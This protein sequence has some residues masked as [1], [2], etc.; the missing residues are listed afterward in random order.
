[1]TAFDVL[2]NQHTERNTKSTELNKPE[3]ESQSGGSWSL[4]KEFSDE[5]RRSLRS[6]S[7]TLEQR[8]ESPDQLPTVEDLPKFAQLYDKINYDH[9][10]GLTKEEVERA[11]SD[12][13]LKSHERQMAEI[14]QNNYDTIRPMGAFVGIDSDK[15]T[16]TD[17]IAVDTLAREGI[18]SE[19]AFLYATSVGGKQMALGTGIVVGSYI[20]SSFVPHPLA[21]L[22]IG[23]AGTVIGGG[24]QGWGAISGINDYYKAKPQLERIRTEIRALKGN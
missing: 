2:N 13:S 8:E 4:Q 7:P 9:A 15:L 23:A 10:R 1:M 17:L 11:V 5:T 21:R 18:T 22:A 12:Q 14:L 24:L 3:Q 19:H 20:V 16:W 6:M